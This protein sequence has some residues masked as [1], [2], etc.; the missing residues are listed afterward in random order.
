VDISVASAPE[1]RERE[2]VTVPPE[3]DEAGDNDSSDSP[4]E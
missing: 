3:T 4:D 1:G 2:K